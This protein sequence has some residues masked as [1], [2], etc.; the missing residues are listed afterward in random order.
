MAD[1]MEAKT[2]YDTILGKL[3]NLMG[4]KE[5]AMT[6]GLKGEHILLEDDYLNLLTDN[7]INIRPEG[8]NRP[9]EPPLTFEDTLQ[10]I[11]TFKGFLP[12]R[13]IM[14]QKEAFFVN[15]GGSKFCLSPKP[16]MYGD[17]LR[18]SNRTG[19]LVSLLETHYYD[20]NVM[21]NMACLINRI[22]Y[23]PRGPDEVYE[24]Y[25]DRIRKYITNSKIL[26]SGNFGLALTSSFK[27][28]ANSLVIKVSL[29]PKNLDVEHELFIGLALNNLRE[30]IPNFTYVYGG[31]RCGQPIRA[32][33]VRLCNAIDKQTYAIYEN[34]SNSVTLSDF[35]A[36]GNYTFQDVFSIYLQILYALD[37][38]H[39]MYDFTH[40]DLHS[41]NILIRDWDNKDK[42][43][44]YP[45]D[46]GSFD[47]IKTRGVATII[48]FGQSHIKIDGINYGNTF[49]DVG[50][51]EN[52][53]FPMND[54]HKSLLYIISGIIPYDSLNLN[55]A[56][57]NERFNIINS[58]VQIYRFFNSDDP[59]RVI[60]NYIK[61]ETYPSE[62]T[63]TYYTIPYI[64]SVGR[65][66]HRDFINYIKANINTDNV[67]FSKDDIPKDEQILTCEAKTNCR[68]DQNFELGILD[69]KY[70][71]EIDNFIT[72]YQDR[73]PKNQGSR[74]VNIRIF[75]EKIKSDTSEYIKYIQGNI[76]WLF[77]LSNNLPNISNPN[78][79][80]NNYGQLL[81]F[82]QFSY[83]MGDIIDKF[84]DYRRKVSVL[85][86]SKEELK[87]DQ[88][89]INSL[90]VSFS[91]LNKFKMSFLDGW[92]KKLNA[93]LEESIE[94]TNGGNDALLKSIS[95]LVAKIYGI[96]NEQQTYWL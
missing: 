45:N 60:D 34:I 73:D 40:F 4:P 41:N 80:R 27:E 14:R 42:Y 77:A 10:F 90:A 16:D 53:S 19:N 15:S 44:P 88:N 82:N 62:I 6:R 54:A 71:V 36:K 8:D 28:A 18:N 64:P 21:D 52:S 11:E 86:L 7:D 74:S 49:L 67:I 33:N 20:K 85:L 50:T 9:I 17:A 95:S 25:K 47:Y 65:V 72:W 29:D 69:I 22:A 84:I 70:G 32:P 96:E 5:T 24:A 46:D 92:Y 68:T 31:F 39:K 58:F 75:N 55:R 63:R 30:W 79:D 87:L 48:D 83:K 26:A 59:Q 38:A 57:Q 3:D 12:A 66:T 89:T 13:Y 61:R 76:Q 56:Q 35:L 91:D 94:N 81:K 43:I 1:E 2:Y 23:L 37:L 51:L 93:A 78:E